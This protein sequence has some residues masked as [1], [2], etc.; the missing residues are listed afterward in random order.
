MPKKPNELEVAG[1]AFCNLLERQAR[2]AANAGDIHGV[3]FL[4]SK[5]R[6]MERLIRHVSFRFPE[7]E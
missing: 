5:M 1:F 3:H 7:E 6:E 2:D 4:V